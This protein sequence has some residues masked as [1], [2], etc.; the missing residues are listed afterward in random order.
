MHAVRWDEH[1]CAI[2]T[3][4]KATAES[5]WEQYSK[6]TKDIAKHR[7]ALFTCDVQARIDHIK[8]IEPSAS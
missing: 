4:P 3:I 5:E 2:V 7:D 6:D 8:K 1:A